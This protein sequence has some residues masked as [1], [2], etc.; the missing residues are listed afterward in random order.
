MIHIASVISDSNIGGAGTVLLTLLKYA[1]LAQFR[2]TVI[3]PLGSKLTPRIRALF[4][5][6]EPV[7]DDLDAVLKTLTDG[8]GA[9]PPV[10]IWEVPEIAEQSY[11][12]A[13]VGVLRMAFAKIRPDVVHTHGSL[14]ARVAA[15]FMRIPAVTTRHSVFEPEERDT[16][17]PRR[18]ILGAVN[19][20]FSKRIIAVSPA[21]AKN[22]T[23]T[24]TL[25]RKIT[26][27]MNGCEPARELTDEESRAAAAEY[28][29]ENAEFVCAIIARLEEVKGHF[30]LIETAKLLREYPIKILAAGTGSLEFELRRH[31]LDEGLRNI[32]FLGFLPDV[33]RLE[34]AMDAQLNCSYG[35]EATSISL[36]EGMSLG[37]PAIVTDFGGNPYVIR[38]GVNG[39]VVPTRH[40]VAM[41][42][43]IL[44]LYRDRELYDELSRG[45]KQAYAE[46]F[47]AETM[48]R[49]TER[50]YREVLEK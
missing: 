10:E 5:M 35:T 6:A 20:F 47:T 40:P 44:R 1:D 2:H 19:N 27:V 22:L 41:A 50:I 12:R 17:F 9:K 28:G 15:K 23:D 21:A 14:S 38:N 34:N 13:G 45:A 30:D 32:D 3:V 43:A 4:G 8:A 39:L 26:V 37:K 18:L 36:L 48:T 25:K 46:G 31:A 29:A 42:E 33:Y 49:A 7:A 24:G 11:S 16:R